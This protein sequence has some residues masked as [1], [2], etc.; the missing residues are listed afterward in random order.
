MKQKHPL[1]QSIYLSDLSFAHRTIDIV[2]REDKV[3]GLNCGDLGRGI[4]KPTKEQKAIL[5]R[6][7]ESLDATKKIFEN[8]THETLVL[9]KHFMDVGYEWENPAVVAVGAVES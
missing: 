7:Q 3:L 2:L 4:R 5:E 1:S 8:L 9:L 6:R